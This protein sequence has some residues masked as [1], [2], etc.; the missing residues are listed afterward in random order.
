MFN[1]YWVIVFSLMHLL[2]F[3]VGFVV[4]GM[5]YTARTAAKR[6]YIF[7]MRWCFGIGAGV[8]VVSVMRYVVDV[9][10]TVGETIK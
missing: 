7:S 6:A 3:C 10:Y 4:Y 5:H 9:L 1:N 2:T 8:F